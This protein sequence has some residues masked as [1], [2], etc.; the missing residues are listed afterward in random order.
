MLQ[1]V[2]SNNLAFVAIYLKQRAHPLNRIILAAISEKLVELLAL[3]F[4]VWSQRQIHFGYPHNSSHH[5]C[6]YPVAA[7]AVCKA[8]D[9]KIQKHRVERHNSAAWDWLTRLV[10]VTGQRCACIWQLVCHHTTAANTHWKW[11]RIWCQCIDVT[12]LLSGGGTWNR[13]L[14]YKYILLVCVCVIN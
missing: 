6:N 9:A 1:S 8:A 2:F 5:R 3:L 4:T 10:L 12:W 14:L 11:A 13:Q 7:A